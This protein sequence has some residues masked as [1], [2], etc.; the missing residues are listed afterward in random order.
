MSI[1]H[2]TRKNISTNNIA[3]LDETAMQAS[4]TFTHHIASYSWFQGTDDGCLY[5]EM[6]ECRAVAAIL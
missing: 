4:K 2:K 6:T 3:V 5:E 1:G